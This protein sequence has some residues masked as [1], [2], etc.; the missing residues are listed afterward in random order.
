MLR[1]CL[2]LSCRV[3]A[4]CCAPQPQAG[5]LLPRILTSL[6][7]RPGSRLGLLSQACVGVAFASASVMTSTCCLSSHLRVFF[8]QASV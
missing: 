4:P 2:G 1:G 8:G 5:V 3:A 7:R 6:W